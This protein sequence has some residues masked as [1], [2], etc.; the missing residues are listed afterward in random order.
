MEQLQDW[1][2]SLGST[3]WV[4][5]ALYAFCVVDGFFPPVPSE[6]LVIALAATWASVGVPNAWLVALAATVGAFT[7]DQ[8][9][10]AIGRRTELRR[11]RPFR[12]PNGRA[13]LDWAERTLHQRGVSFIVTARF[14]PVGRVA[15]NMT[16]GSLRFPR[17]RFV[18]IT[19]LAAVLWAAYGVAI[20]V[21]A[22]TWFR[23]QPLLAVAVGIGLG[24]G[25]GFLLDPLLRRVSG[26]PP[27]RTD[28]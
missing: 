8:V 24:L 11:W 19:L 6:S 5:L 4:Y 22:G 28:G 3:P 16:A 10:Y 1:V 25:L 13:V 12:H 14:V 7:G 15:V 9:A 23:D 21:F 27:R 2:V 18:P 17:R 20:G 26:A